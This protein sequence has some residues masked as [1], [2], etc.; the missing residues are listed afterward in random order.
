MDLIPFGEKI[1]ETKKCRI[2]GRDFFVTDKDLE[3][4]ERVSPVFQ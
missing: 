1:I 2:S 4:L 3:F